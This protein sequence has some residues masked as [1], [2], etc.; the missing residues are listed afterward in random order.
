MELKI[1]DE[2]AAVLGEDPDREALEVLLLQLSRSDRVSVAWAGGVLGLDRWEAIEWY[3]SHGYHYPDYTAEDLEEDLR[4]ARSFP[5]ADRRHGEGG[6]GCA[7]S[8]RA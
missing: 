2:V 4:Y 6:V 7:G 1:Q 3:T 5:Q 8:S